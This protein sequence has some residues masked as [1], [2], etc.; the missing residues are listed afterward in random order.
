MPKQSEKYISL[1]EAAKISGY[2]SDYI[3]QLIRQG[4]LPGKQVFSNVAWMTTR[5]AIEQYKNGESAYRSRSGL[6]SR[7]IAD[8]PGLY[9]LL[10][11]LFF[12]AII[13]L[14]VFALFLFYVFSTSVEKDTE[15]KALQK[16]E[17]VQYE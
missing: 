7:G 12:L 16:T 9:G 14:A 17:A 3:G 8:F 5:E 13:L 11:G 4:K 6:A 1:K 2:S 15:R 10:R